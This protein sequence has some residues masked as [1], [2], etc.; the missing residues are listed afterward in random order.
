MSE[1]CLVKG[2]HPFSRTYGANLPISLSSVTPT[3]LGLYSQGHL[4]RISV[5][6]HYSPFHGLQDLIDLRMKRLGSLLAVTALHELRRLD[7]AT[8]PL[9][10]SRS[11]SFH[12]SEAQEY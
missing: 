12:C 1:I 2:R 10:L 11:V 6:S 4:C 5:R 7:D 8:A 9:D 3:R